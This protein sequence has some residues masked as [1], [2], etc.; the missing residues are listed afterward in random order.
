MHKSSSI[1][2]DAAHGQLDCAIFPLLCNA[3]LLDGDDAGP[4]G[5]GDSCVSLGVLHPLLDPQLTIHN[6]QALL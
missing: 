3:D 5:L 1:R 6:L 2:F 4:R